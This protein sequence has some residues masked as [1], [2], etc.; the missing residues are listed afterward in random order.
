MGRGNFF[1]RI[2]TW[3]NGETIGTQIFTWRKGIKVGEDD[4]GN[5]Y[6]RDRQDKRRWVIYNGEVEA[7]R[8]SPEWH[9]WLHKTWKNP[10]SEEE[11]MRKKWE[12]PHQENLTGSV[13]AYAPSGSMRNAK[14]KETSDYEPWTPN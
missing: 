4:Q 12:K 9:G 2:F 3:W 8:V 14:A 6:F 1:S 10:P 5:L 7:S 11:I 13:L